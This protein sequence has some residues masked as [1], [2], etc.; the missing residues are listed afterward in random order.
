[1]K[2]QKFF[3]IKLESKRFAQNAKLARKKKE[4]LAKETV[5]LKLFIRA[6]KTEIQHDGENV[7]KSCVTIYLKS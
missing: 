2:V 3:N 7:Y 1:M 6:G 4:K 5:W